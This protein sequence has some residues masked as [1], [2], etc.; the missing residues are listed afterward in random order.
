LTG[1]K[2][3]RKTWAVLGKDR[4]KHKE[5]S[6]VVVTPK[7]RETAIDMGGSKK[8]THGVP[9]PSTEKRGQKKK[10][11]S[12]TVGHF[13]N[14]ERSTP[15]SP[16]TEDTECWNISAPVGNHGTISWN[17]GRGLLNGAN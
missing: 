4:K 7:G 5:R 3:G 8:R 9:E 14:G 6:H 15:M 17:D 13:R 1:K 11:S 16:G 12:R 10:A 2:R